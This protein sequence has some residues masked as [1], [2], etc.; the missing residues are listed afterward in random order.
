[1]LAGERGP[2]CN[3]MAQIPNKKVFYVLFVKPEGELDEEEENRSR[4]VS[5]L[6][7]T[8]SFDPG[9]R[10]T[11]SVFKKSIHCCD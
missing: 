9:I 2:S 8:R 4:E 11:G 7:I 1:M 3:K 5:V 10:L 6:I